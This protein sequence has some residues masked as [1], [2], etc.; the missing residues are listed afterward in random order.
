MTTFATTLWSNSAFCQGN[1]TLEVQPSSVEV[2]QWYHEVQARVTF[3]N[4]GPDVLVQPKLDAFTND[5][6]QPKIDATG[7]KRVPSGTNFGLADYVKERRSRRIPGTVQF[8]ATY[9]ASGKRGLQHQYATLSVKRAVQQENPLEISIQGLV[10]SI[11]EN[12]PGSAYVIIKNNLEMPVKIS[13]KMRPPQPYTV[14]CKS[15]A[16]LDVPPHSTES[17]EMVISAAS[18]VTPGR[19]VIEF[20]VTAEWDEAGYHQMRVLTVD[21]EV[22]VGVFFESDL[23]KVLG[24]PSFLILPGALVLFTMQLLL[25]FGFLSLNRFSKVPDLP[26][27]SPGF[28]ILAITISG[29]F[30]ATYNEL[31]GTDFLVGYGPRD[32]RNVWLS[33][34]LLGLLVYVLLAGITYKRRRERVPDYSDDQIATLEKMGRRGLGIL[35]NRVA[36]QINNVQRTAYLIELIE[37]GQAMVWVAPRLVLSGMQKTRRHRKTRR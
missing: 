32:L 3:K 6:F 24:V 20:P 5:S 26:V 31:T 22:S 27:T 16:F 4:G 18:Q 11:A 15:T 17:A 30:D 2:S 33:S 29:L 10:D 37:D 13:V 19:Y 21:K 35:A 25:S 1:V 8:D 9:L 34:I 23:L 36:F 28:W 12:R 14:E 7:I